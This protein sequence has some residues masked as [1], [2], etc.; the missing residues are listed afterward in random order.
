[1]NLISHALP[2]NAF[3]LQIE[4]KMSAYS[5][6]SLTVKC[7]ACMLKTVALH[8]EIVNQNKPQSC[9]IISKAF[10]V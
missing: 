2:T 3:A 1:M 5:S 7:S 6:I 8:P 9:E 4:I 10:S